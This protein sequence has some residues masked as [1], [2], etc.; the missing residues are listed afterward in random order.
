MD[1]KHNF[2]LEDF[3]GEE[4]KN[5]PIKNINSQTKLSEFA[6]IK[7]ATIDPRIHKEISLAVERIRENLAKLRSSVQGNNTKL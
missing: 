1:K 3:I 7:V 4:V 2:E 6:H 5:S